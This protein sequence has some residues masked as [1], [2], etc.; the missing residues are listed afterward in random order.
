[1]FP[2]PE[3]VKGEKE[4]DRFWHKVSIIQDVSGQDRYPVLTKLA[5]AVLTIPH[6]NADTER[7]FSQIGLDETIVCSR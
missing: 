4:V 7:L 5:K 2:L 6:G 3:E 1:M